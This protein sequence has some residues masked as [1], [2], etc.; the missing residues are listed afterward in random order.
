MRNQPKR[1]SI[2]RLAPVVC[3]VVM[4]TVAWGCQRS[5]SDELIDISV[6]HL[7]AAKRL[8]EEADGD[9]TKLA[10]AVM[11]YRLAHR[12]EFLALRNKGNE[13]IKG[14]TDEERKQFNDQARIRTLSAMDMLKTASRKFEDPRMALQHVA[15]LILRLSPG[16]QVQKKG[17][18]RPWM[19]PLPDLPGHEHVD[20]PAAITRTR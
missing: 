17:A 3:A 13:M 7:K 10:V 14:M 20:E 18:R 16:V 4:V 9:R 5:K 12:D 2:S 6:V 11:H 19:P 8:M 15:P 1:S